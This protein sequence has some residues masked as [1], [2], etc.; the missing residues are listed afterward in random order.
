MPPNRFTKNEIIKSS[1]AIYF[2]RA[3]FQVDLS[4]PNQTQTQAH[5]SSC[6]TSFFESR[7]RSPECGNSP[8]PRKADWI[9]ACATIG[10]ND[11]ERK[12]SHM[13]D[14]CETGMTGANFVFAA[15]QRFCG[16]LVFSP[17]PTNSTYPFFSR[18]RKYFTKSKFV[19]P[20][21]S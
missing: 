12:L 11:G 21:S 9:P 20:V 15:P 13:S 19:E 5:R 14:S 8:S 16:L 18:K 3:Y 1:D 6:L 2:C 17:P 7:V 10:R 4:H